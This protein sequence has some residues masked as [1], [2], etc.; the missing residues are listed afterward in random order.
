MFLYFIMES[1]TKYMNREAPFKSEYFEDFKGVNAVSWWKM[2]KRLGFPE[3]LVKV[4]MG[5]L[6]G[7][8]NSAVL[9]RCFSTAGMT[10]GKLRTQMDV[11]K[12]GKLA[13]LYQQM[14]LPFYS[15]YSIVVLF[16]WSYCA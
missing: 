10:Y 6:S 13:F 1:V 8:P 15:S 7:I 2:G 9:E 5:L 3:P 16:C 11:E 12:C 4:V 14:K